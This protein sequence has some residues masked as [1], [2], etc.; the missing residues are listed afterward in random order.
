MTIA[1]TRRASVF[2]AGN[3]SYQ[4]VIP[5]HILRRVFKGLFCL[6]EWALDGK[7]DEYEIKWTLLDDGTITVAF[8]PKM[9]NLL[10]NT[11]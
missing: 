9:E 1:K 2:R 10:K 6:D 4:C 7:P 3:G 11:E 5:K 8:I